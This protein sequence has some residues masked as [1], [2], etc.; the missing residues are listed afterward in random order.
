MGKFITKAETVYYTLMKDFE[1]KIKELHNNAIKNNIP[2]LLTGIYCN[3]SIFIKD[4]TLVNNNLI[5]I[6][7]NIVFIY[8]SY[9]RMTVI[10]HYRK[11]HLR[12]IHP[13]HASHENLH[14]NFIQLQ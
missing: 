2:K 3:I 11:I 10:H 12:K 1:K 13:N 7:K 8:T 9:I 4:L 6:E 14:S 5:N